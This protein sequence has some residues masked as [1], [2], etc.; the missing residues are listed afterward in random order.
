MPHA[1][2]Y[3]KYC[4]EHLSINTYMCCCWCLPWQ[5]RS[6]NLPFCLCGTLIPP[7]LLNILNPYTYYIPIY[8]WT[9]MHIYKCSRA[10]KRY[11]SIYTIAHSYNVSKISYMYLPT[12]H[13]LLRTTKYVYIGLWIMSNQLL[14]DKSQ[15]HSSCIYLQSTNKNI[16]I[17]LKFNALIFLIYIYIHIYGKLRA[18][19]QRLKKQ[20][21]SFVAL[22]VYTVYTIC[23]HIV[24]SEQKN[25]LN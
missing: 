4:T 9:Q 20:H 1:C 10:I 14:I 21:F 12:A 23:M 11:A 25:K 24:W 17:L 13:I 16:H 15:K 7:Y 5:V 8:R 22:W 2:T 19:A 18:P 3:T 6:F